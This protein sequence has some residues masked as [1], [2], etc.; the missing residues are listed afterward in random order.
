MQG[1]ID[2]MILIYNEVYLGLVTAFDTLPLLSNT[3]DF[4]GN[5]ITFSVLLSTFI[6]LIVYFGIIYFV[7]S[8]ITKVVR[9]LL[10]W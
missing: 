2:F 6:S 9:R 10:I 8:V 3:L 7:L 5:E 1:F 4:Y